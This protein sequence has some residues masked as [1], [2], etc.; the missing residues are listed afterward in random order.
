MQLLATIYN[1]F[2]IDLLH[3]KSRSAEQAVTSENLITLAKRK[4]AILDEI[5]PLMEKISKS[6]DGITHQLE[7]MCQNAELIYKQVNIITENVPNSVNHCD[8][9]VA[10]DMFGKR[11]LGQVTWQIKM[12]MSSLREIDKALDESNDQINVI[13]GM[14][15]LIRDSSKKIL[16]LTLSVSFKAG[17]SDQEAGSFAVFSDEIRNFSERIVHSTKQIEITLSEAQTKTNFLIESMNKGF[18]EVNKGL[19]LVE[20]ANDSFNNINSSVCLANKDI[21]NTIRLLWSIKS[22]NGKLVESL[23]QMDQLRNVIN[24]NI[25]C[26]WAVT[27]KRPL[28]IE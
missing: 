2:V 20:Q 11:L 8:Y 21:N 27:E 3:L 6:T 18:W 7:H 19:K 23:D 17:G 28:V 15:H 5:V 25:E 1:K 12:I 10:T 22:D 4:K 14:N 16:A 9:R 13:R 24:Y 26:V